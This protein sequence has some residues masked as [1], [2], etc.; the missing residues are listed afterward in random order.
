MATD[1]VSLVLDPKF[2]G[3]L[4]EC[5]KEV[6]EA[7]GKIVAELQPII[8]HLPEVI[9]KVLPDA[10]KA[11]LVFMSVYLLHQT[12]GFFNGAKELETEYG[13]YHEKKFEVL[14]RNKVKTYT[15]FID[16]EI[17]PKWKKGN[18]DN[19][20]KVTDELLG[21]MKHELTVFQELI[22]S[23][24]SDTKKAGSHIRW[25]VFNSVIAVAFCGFSIHS[26]N[27]KVICGTCGATIGTVIYTVIT[28]RSNTDTLTK[29]DKYRE[30]ACKILEEIC[31]YH[32]QLDIARMRGELHI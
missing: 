17:I 4:L 29:L 16:T 1:T 30:G 27:C 8:N 3:N 7:G 21:K 28:Y 32:A 20:R 15:D 5:T 22:D 11:G 9:K 10:T 14:K 6:L 18:A 2:I 24:H 19:L 26:G 25:S 13:V 31:K 23:I 12:F